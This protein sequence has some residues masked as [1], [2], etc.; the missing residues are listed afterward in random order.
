MYRPAQMDAMPSGVLAC[1]MQMRAAP[2]ASEWLKRARVE[3]RGG[4]EEDGARLAQPRARAQ[5]RAG[6]GD[7]VLLHPAGVRLRPLVP[8]HI[9]RRGVPAR[10][11]QRAQRCVR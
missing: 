8:V 6:V 5:G 11:P 2:D 3:R 7:A 9:E 4:R 1:E 10:V